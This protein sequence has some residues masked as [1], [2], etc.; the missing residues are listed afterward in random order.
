MP[1]QPAASTR[2]RHPPLKQRGKKSRENE[3]ESSGDDVC[4]LSHSLT[5]TDKKR[6]NNF[7]NR[8]KLS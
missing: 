5:M 2:P 4:S 6:Q 8:S 1:T 7:L 3:E